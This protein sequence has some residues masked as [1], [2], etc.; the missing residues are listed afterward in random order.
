MGLF[1]VR[2]KGGSLESRVGLAS[3]TLAPE[4]REDQLKEFVRLRAQDPVERSIRDWVGASANNV[5]SLTRE[6]TSTPIT[7]TQVVDMSAEQARE[8]REA[9]PNVAVIPDQPLPLIPPSRAAAAAVGRLTQTRLW[10]LDALRL[11][12]LRRSGFGLNG[13]GVTVAVL[14]TGIDATHSEFTSGG[15][16]RVAGAFTFDVARWQ[17]VPLVPSIDTDGHGTHV[18]GLVCG[19]KVG[20]APGAR[21]LSGVMIPNGRGNLSDFILA[22]EWAAAQPA[23]QIVNVSA[24]IPG[25]LSEMHQV[26]A[27]LLAVGVLPVVAAGNEGRNKTRSPGNYAEVLSV[28]AATRGKKIASFSSSGAVLADNHLYT[29]PDLVAPGAGVYSCVMGGG[30]QPWDGTSMAAPLVS[31]VAALAIQKHPRI[32]V[33]DLIDHL[34]GTCKRLA[35]AEIRQGHGLVQVVR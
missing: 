9:L 6:E 26:L 29:K 2:R 5:R 15:P 33:T 12:G 22:L 18:A 35:E 1:I 13:D 14:D 31:G 3:Q 34:L 4:D 24:G 8:L 16:N 23:V 32:T 19:K 30:Y 7:G 20:V 28:G 25:Y 21:V 27:D 11:T 17:A 10:H